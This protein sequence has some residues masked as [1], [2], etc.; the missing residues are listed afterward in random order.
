MARR[1]RTTGFT[2]VELLVV[3][4][5]IMILASITYPALVRSQI[6]AREA[7][8]RSNLKQ[9]A[10]GLYTYALNYD[11]MYVAN[12]PPELLL[13]K[14]PDPV[15]NSYDDFSPLYG[16]W[17]CRIGRKKITPTDP[18]SKYVY[19]YQVVKTE[20]YVPDVRVFNCPTT[21]DRAGTLPIKEDWWKQICRKRTG[22]AMKFV[23][24]AGK[25]TIQ[26]TAPNL[27]V[28]PPQ[29]SYEYCGEFRPGMNLPG[30]NASK[31]WLVHDED[32]ANEN[33]E[34]VVSKKIYDSLKLTRNSN[35]GTRGGNILFLDTHAEWVNPIDWPGRVG[36]GI[37][38][39]SDTVSWSLPSMFWGIP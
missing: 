2:L 32:A 36:K 16:V 10:T 35:H 31:A 27:Q 8:C 11:R 3:I 29:L 7:Q 38:E 23:W 20:S 12:R 22:Y 6:Q 39:W 14:I 18:N 9:I 17:S 28:P 19:T 5:I 15:F 4:G 37:E 13:Q 26:Q 24:S 1:R 30:I 33:I 34:D 21:R 25:Y